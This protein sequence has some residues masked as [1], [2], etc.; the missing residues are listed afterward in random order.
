MDPQTAMRE[1]REHNW[2]SRWTDKNNS[3]CS[4]LQMQLH[5]IK[6]CNMVLLILQ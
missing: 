5:G 6:W 4:D 3:T 1:Q 2:A